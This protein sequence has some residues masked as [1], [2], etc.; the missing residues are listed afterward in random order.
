MFF[1]SHQEFAGFAALFDFVC[2][3]DAA[4]ISTYD[5]RFSVIPASPSRTDTAVA[6]MF[7]LALFSASEGQNY[8]TVASPTPQPN[9]EYGHH[10]LPFDIGYPY[11]IE[12]AFEDVNQVT[13]S[14]LKIPTPT[15]LSPAVKAPRPYHPFITVRHYH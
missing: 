5:C 1:F 14:S 7:C 13:A 6:S 11:V 12:Q 9:I 15:S 2:A 4:P 3:D 8:M 10:T